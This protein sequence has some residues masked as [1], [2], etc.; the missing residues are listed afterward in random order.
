MPKPPGDDAPS[1]TGCVAGACAR[2]GPGAVG[3]SQSPWLEDRGPELTL[4]IAVGDATGTE[5]QAAFHTT[6]DSR[7]YL[8]LLEALVRRRGSFY[9]SS[10][11]RAVDQRYGNNS[12]LAGTG[13]SG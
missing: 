4:L 6:E 12:A 9:D 7:E 1:S 13:T 2:R 10:D 11:E 3:G 5:A 8:M